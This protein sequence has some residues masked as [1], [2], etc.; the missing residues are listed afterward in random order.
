MRFSG[1]NLADFAAFRQSG[2]HLFQGDRSDPIKISI[3]ICG[4]LS[5]LTNVGQLS[6]IVFSNLKP[7]VTAARS[8]CGGAA[9]DEALIVPVAAWASS[10]SHKKSF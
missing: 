9:G 7:A 2:R 3:S 5:N 10:S 1:Y 8:P 4:S 6:N